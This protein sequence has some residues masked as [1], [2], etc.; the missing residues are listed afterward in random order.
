MRKFGKRLV[1]L[2]ASV[3]FYRFVIIFFVFQSL[4][5]TFSAA[6]P[7]AF[8]ENFHFGL[9]RLYSHYWLPFLKGQPVGANQYGAV[10]RDPSYL[11]HYLMSFP[12]RFINLFTHSQAILVISMRLIDV[13]FFTAGLIIFRKVMLRA[14]LSKA[15][16]NVSLLIFVLIP[17][18]PQL[19]GQ[20]NYDD[21]LFLLTAICCYKAFD[22]IDAIRSKTVQLKQALILACLLILSS[23]V[24]YAF[25][26]IAAAIFLYVLY[27]FYKTFKGK[28]KAEFSKLIKG[29]LKLPYFYKFLLV[30]LL[31]LSIFMFIQ[32]DGYNLVKY[33]SVV[34]NCSKVLSVK[35]CSSYSA[36]YTDYMRHNLVLGGQASNSE[37]ILIYVGQ[38]FYWMW[39]RLFFAINGNFFNNPPLLLP[40]IGAVILGV[41]AVYYVW[42]WR[43]KIFKNRYLMLFVTISIIYSLSLFIKGYATYKYTGTLENMNGRYLVPILLPAAAIAGLALSSAFRKSINIRVIATVVILILFL[44][45]G[46]VLT[47]IVN[48]DSSWYWPNTTVNKINKTAKKIATH[49]VVKKAVR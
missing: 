8:D 33:H 45:G 23:L 44:E 4:W 5:I 2:V 36:W 17:I 38:W 13:I 7:Q 28:I 41:A 21:L 20:I 31:I 12:Y 37:N 16:T 1:H 35:S 34:P 29:F 6:Y 24:K 22:I 19:A 32:R 46:G 3:G 15:F 14:G 47:F 9:I 11:Y 10:A 27:E 26:P 30:G 25:L 18:V 48:S 42:K 49:I 39:Y 40:S 43:A